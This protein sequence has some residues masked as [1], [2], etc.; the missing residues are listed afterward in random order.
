MNYA[1]IT[2]T[3]NDDLA[4]RNTWDI[5]SNPGSNGAAE[6]AVEPGFPA[7][8]NITSM[9]KG[10]EEDDH[11][12]AGIEIFDLALMTVDDTDILANYGDNVVHT[13]TVT[14]QGSI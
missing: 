6:N 8:D 3:Y 5:D 1:E 12:P 4:P 10:G 7:D 13:I 9:D 11:D 2:D 14:N